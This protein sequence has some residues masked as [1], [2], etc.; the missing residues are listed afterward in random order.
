MG[1]ADAGALPLRALGTY[2]GA[3][4]LIADE[5]GMDPGPELQ[6][7]QRRILVGDPALSSGLSSGYRPQAGSGER[8]AVALS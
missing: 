6:A 2:R 8:P 7:L 1:A 3:A 5:V 4:E